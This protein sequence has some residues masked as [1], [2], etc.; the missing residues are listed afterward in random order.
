M[1]SDAGRSFEPTVPLA[2]SFPSFEPTVVSFN[3]SLPSFEPTEP[4]P[5][6]PPPNAPSP[7]WFEKPSAMPSSSPTQAPTG[8]QDL[9]ASPSVEIKTP[10][11]TTEDLTQA[12]TAKS[13]ESPVTSTP[14]PTGTRVLLES[15]L[16]MRVEMNDTNNENYKMDVKKLD[17]IASSIKKYL[18]QQLLSGSKPQIVVDHVM[19]SKT[20]SLRSNTRFL[21]E[22]SNRLSYDL[23]VKVFA[24]A[25]KD[26][27]LSTA[28]IEAL[29]SDIRGFSTALEDALD[30]PV[31]KVTIG[32]DES[33]A[34]GSLVD[35]NE[36][37]KSSF[38]SSTNIAMLALGGSAALISMITALILK[39]NKLKRMRKVEEE[40]RKIQVNAGKL[41]GD[42]RESPQNS[43]Y[44]AYRFDAEALEKREL[45]E[46][47]NLEDDL[48]VE[49][50]RKLD[51][52]NAFEAS[53]TRG[54]ANKFNGVNKE[55]NDFTTEYERYY[56]R[57][58]MSAAS[59]TVSSLSSTSLKKNH[60]RHKQQ[61][62][63]PAIDPSIGSYESYL[64][65]NAE[66]MGDIL[67]SHST[68]GEE[69]YRQSSLVNLPL[70]IDDS[71]DMPI[72][73]SEPNVELKYP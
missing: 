51:H 27:D 44:S 25:E 46:E 33:S 41:L 11:P 61:G 23:R 12:P 63:R 39:M 18:I 28:L 15:L 62:F 20:K 66:L 13:T 5:P 2:T 21:Q 71:I 54:G 14:S 73:E 42:S 72:V 1:P 29:Q 8:N 26:F 56:R 67:R 4:L 3:T 53:L 52:E 45:S 36:S 57:S 59:A 16:S 17:E 7:V 64:G 65:S 35:G 40:R 47:S 31:A 60:R 19:V 68:E 49:D 30:A 6:P 69:M 55:G 70:P 38:W 32:E 58:Q 48:S 24:F 50:E 37:N 43:A 9:S 10:N 22:S 34:N